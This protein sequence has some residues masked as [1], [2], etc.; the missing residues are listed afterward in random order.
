M[1]E[2]FVQNIGALFA[3]ENGEKNAAAKNRIDEAGRVARQH[4]AIAG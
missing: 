2:H 1:I 3:A 4:P